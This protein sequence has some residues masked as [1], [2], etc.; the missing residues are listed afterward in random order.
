MKN[1]R[2]LA[3]DLWF[4]KMPDNPYDPCPCGCGLKW[5]FVIRDEKTAAEHE[6][7]FIKDFVDAMNDE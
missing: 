4:E 6:E 1:L 3:S 2:G 7:K 5:R